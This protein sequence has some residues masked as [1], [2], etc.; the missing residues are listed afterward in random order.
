VLMH[1]AVPLNTA[2]DAAKKFAAEKKKLGAKRRGLGKKPQ[3]RGWV[4]NYA[5]NNWDE[6]LCSICSK[7]Q[8]TN[9]RKSNSNIKA[10]YKT[11]HLAVFEDV[12]ALEEDAKAAKK[13][14]VA[15]D[16]KKIL[17]EAHAAYLLEQ[18]H[19]K[20]K[21]MQQLNVSSSAHAYTFVINDR[22]T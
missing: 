18:K 10:H 14:L 3:K 11:H 2:G 16:Y 5:I 21:S 12:T 20:D 7:Q 15:D 4:S 6:R 8:S 19:K 1:A 13:L 9:S 17:N 22:S